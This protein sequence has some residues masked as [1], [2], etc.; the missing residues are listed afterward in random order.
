M[1]SLEEHLR[2]VVEENTTCDI[3]TKKHDREDIFLCGFQDPQNKRV[4]LLRICRTDIVVLTSPE[5]RAALDKH[6]YA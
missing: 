1:K 3:C 2:E 5:L 4:A 6:W